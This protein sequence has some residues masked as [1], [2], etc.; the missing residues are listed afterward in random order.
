VLSASSSG[1]GSSLPLPT[2]VGS[3]YILTPTVGL[4]LSLDKLRRNLLL[5]SCCA[6]ISSS[7]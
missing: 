7:L 4:R 5:A 2:A 1:R 3:Q 6:S